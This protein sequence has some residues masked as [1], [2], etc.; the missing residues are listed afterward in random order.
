[1]GLFVLFLWSL[2][3]CWWLCLLC[4]KNSLIYLLTWFFT[5]WRPC[6]KFILPP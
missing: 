1:V 2:N 6:F 3:C 4:A 5:S